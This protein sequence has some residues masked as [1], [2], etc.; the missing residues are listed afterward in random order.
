MIAAGGPQVAVNLIGDDPA[1]WVERAGPAQRASCL[2]VGGRRARSTSAGTD[3]PMYSA[4]APAAR[5]APD[6]QTLSSVMRYLAPDD[7]TSADD[8]RAALETHAAL[9]GLPPASE[10]TL[11]R[12]LAAC[13][14]TGTPQ[15]GVDRPTGLELAERGIY[16][17]GDW[18]GR[19]LL[20]D[21]SLVSGATAGAAAA[22][23]AMVA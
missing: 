6:G 22:E 16:A 14:A 23:R 7:A 1:G 8:N 5:L 17:A 15:V 20:A 12:F 9:A 11:D 18:V 10:R 3:T 21:A 2:D 19:P 4:H 13:T